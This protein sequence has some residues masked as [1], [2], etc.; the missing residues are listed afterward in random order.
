MKVI[1]RI[2][3]TSNSYWNSEHYDTTY[4]ECETEEEYQNKFAQL[5]AEVQKITDEYRKFEAQGCY[6]DEF[7]V[8]GE[9][10]LAQA[11]NERI[12]L[13]DEQS[14]IANEYYENREWQGMSFKA[15]GF[16]YSV[17][18][19]RGYNTEYYLKPKSV[20][21]ITPCTDRGIGWMYGS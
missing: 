14:V 1:Y 19:E 6:K 11:L 15:V 8:T 7:F 5:K 16:C 12:S 18:Y 9:P 20:S 13:S 3:Q 4:Y 21:D 2:H 10:Y 17:H